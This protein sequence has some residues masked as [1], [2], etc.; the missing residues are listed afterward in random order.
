ML[1]VLFCAAAFASDS[2][3]TNM[4]GMRLVKIPAGTFTMGTTDLE[5]AAMERPDGKLG[6]VQDEAPAHKV[7]FE[8]AF[9][10]SAT[11]VT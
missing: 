10:M 1:F 8:K 11:E 4:I 7:K 3:V 5:E 9:Y 6:M 2:N